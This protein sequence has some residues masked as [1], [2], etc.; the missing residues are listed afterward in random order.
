MITLL[1]GNLVTITYDRFGYSSE[2][3]L[4]YGININTRTMM[5]EYIVEIKS[6]IV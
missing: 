2:I 3:G 4:I 5:A 6:I 1:V